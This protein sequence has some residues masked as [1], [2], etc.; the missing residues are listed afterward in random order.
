MDGSHPTHNTQ[1]PALGPE[2]AERRGR[3]L[4]I[5]ADLADIGMELVEHVRRQALE[6]VTPGR[7]DPVLAFE[8]LAKAVRQTIA[9]EAKVAAGG[10]DIPQPAARKSAATAEFGFGLMKTRVRKRVAEAIASD[11]DPGDAEHL[12][13]DLD[14]RLDDPE[15]MEEMANRPFGMIVALICGALNVEI[16]LKYFTD[17]ELG[18][19]TEAMRNAPRPA[20]GDAAGMP[21]SHGWIRGLEPPDWPPPDGTGSDPP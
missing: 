15:Y 4:R 17:A 13:R 21:A 12:L 1:P 5:L 18:F 6:E 14:E 3:H 9:L 16:D 7:A 10:F 19:D 20:R 2:A 11:A 8:R